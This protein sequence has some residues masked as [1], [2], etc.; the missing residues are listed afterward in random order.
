[1]QPLNNIIIPKFYYTTNYITQYP[2]KKQSF[3]YKEY[4]N[5]NTPS[6]QFT[7]KEYTMYKKALKNDIIRLD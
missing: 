5:W 1:M 6:P 4:I 3:T 2:F 7:M